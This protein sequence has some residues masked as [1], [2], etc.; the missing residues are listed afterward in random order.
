[1]ENKKH[2]ENLLLTHY[3]LWKNHTR[4]SVGEDVKKLKP[5]YTVDSNAN[6][7]NTWKIVLGV[8]QKAYHKVSIWLWISPSRY[9]LRKIKHMF[10]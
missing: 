3:N 5:S 2:S 9:L 4:T 8:S 6:D 7:A 10:I 1:M